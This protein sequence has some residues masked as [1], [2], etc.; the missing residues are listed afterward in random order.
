[1]DVPN[2]QELMRPLLEMLREHGPVR[3]RD[4]YDLVAQRL[5]ITPG[6]REVLLP[7]G[8]QTLFENRVGWAK[9]YLKKAGLVTNPK[10]GVWG[11]SER[12]R[13]L[14]DAHAG[15]ISK[16]TLM[17]FDS[18]VDFHSGAGGASGTSAGLVDSAGNAP[19]DAS[20]ATPTEAIEAA[21]TQL[22]D[23]L[24]SELLDRIKD[25]TP[26]F[27]EQLV[28]D[29]MLAMG[30]GGSR[31]EAGEA[32][33]LNADGGID[34]LIREDRLGLDT[35]YLQ[36]KRWENTVGRPEVQKF[37]GALQGER[38]RKG[39][40]ITTSTFSDNARRYVERLD[41][42]IVLID[43]HRLATLMMDHGVGVSRRERYDVQVVDGDYFE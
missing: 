11:L 12:G 28:V 18:F 22:R 34:G 41:S 20:V 9:T 31:K 19:D 14:L 24:A 7:S 3:S 37:A 42:R 21:Y 2:Y 33:Q 25:N 29:L 10:R 23:E 6:A 5:G 35:I 16:D 38:A 8:R 40:M 26:A 39:V 13:Q 4:A 36:A 27:F 43:G 30:Y 1:M 32:T 17:S 15:P